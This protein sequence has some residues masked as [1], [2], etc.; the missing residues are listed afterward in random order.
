MKTST[1]ALILFLI[2]ILVPTY[3]WLAP[4]PTQNY[5]TFRTYPT[6]G[7]AIQGLINGQINLLPI[8]ATTPGIIS[9]LNN[10][11]VNLV[12]ISNFGFT[13]IGVNMKNSPLNDTKLRE[14]M[15][16]GFNRQ[17]VLNETISDYGELLNAGL[18]SSAYEKLGWKNDS[19][20]AYNYNPEMA[21]SLLD[22][23]GY[24]L[25]GQYRIDPATGD[26]M[27]TIFILSRLDDPANVA[28]A[29]SFA[30]DMQAIGLPIINYP[31]P[32]RDFDFQVKRTYL[33]DLYIDTVSA[34]SG[35]TWLYDLFA[36]NND[37]S[38]VP[39]GS[40]RVGYHNSNFDSCVKQ[41]MATSNV[42]VIRTQILECQGIL[43]G[44]LPALPVYSRYSLIATTLDPSLVVPITGSLSATIKQTILRVESTSNIKSLTI[45]IVGAFGNLD[46]T[47]TS[48]PA[49]WTLLNLMLEPLVSLNENGIPTPGIADS[50]NLSNDGQTIT[51]TLRD[52]LRFNDG[53]PI[54]LNDLTATIDWLS[55][56]VKPSSPL[57]A[58]LKQIQNVTTPDTRT[59]KISLRQPD[60]FAVYS[61]GHLF[62]LP[63]SRLDPNGDSSIPLGFLRNHS[64]VASG[65]FTISAFDQ[66]NGANF[67]INN[68]YFNSTQNISSG[69]TIFAGQGLDLFAL[70][71]PQIGIGAPAKTYEGQ[72]IS[73]ATYSVYIYDQNSSLSTIMNGS[74]AIYGAYLAVFNAN[75][76]LIKEGQYRVEG[77][78]F[79][80][81]PT[82]MFII[83]P[84]ETLIVQPSLPLDSITV[85]IVATIA[86]LLVWRQHLL[87]PHAL[88]PRTK[89]V[90]STRRNR[91]TKH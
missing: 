18:F 40:N 8:D 44:D 22:S 13:Y 41:M 31:V 87:E 37:N 30:R 78:L 3:T 2:L 61:L 86:A 52:N 56:N 9:E 49:D 62:I 26:R 17:K 76:P 5:L 10:S 57:Y 66:G 89:R 73:N 77:Q 42:E 60:A 28:A 15:L 82:G 79:G 59:L 84:T 64:I 7:N 33:T 24:N 85:A 35:P 74:Y 19:A 90:G 12:T 72:S 47:S 70:G 45:G 54:T 36:S 32:S 21:K 69:N 29:D 58:V 11:N 34:D 51:F 46:P 67:E 83:F 16:Y 39:L 63:A 71:N 91:I 43:S 65:P 68:S 25:T 48:N 4:R 53:Q 55:S 6:I 88:K 80:I 23:A 27:R 20:N 14:A 38:P 50:W 75:S 81:L 1:A